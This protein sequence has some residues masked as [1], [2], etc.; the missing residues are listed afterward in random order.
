MLYPVELRMHASPQILLTFAFTTRPQHLGILA[1]DHPTGKNGVKRS[2]WWKIIMRVV[3]SSL[4]FASRG[5]P[6]NAV[7]ARVSI[8]T[9]C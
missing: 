6:A 9:R 3:G 7:I 2:C 8:P 1:I 4:Y 5:G